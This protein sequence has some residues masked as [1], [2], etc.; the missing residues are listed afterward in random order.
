MSSVLRRVMHFSTTSEKRIKAHEVK[1]VIPVALYHD[2]SVNH[3]LPLLKEVTG[4]YS[5]KE[6]QAKQISYSV[7][8]KI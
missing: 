1:M 4:K 5:N 3:C 8:S 6:T 7:I 2:W